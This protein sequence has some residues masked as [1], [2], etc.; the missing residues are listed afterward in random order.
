M[1]HPGIK[2][3][4]LAGKSVEDIPTY[5]LFLISPLYDLFFAE[6]SFNEANIE[7]LEIKGSFAKTTI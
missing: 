3:A 4:H 5:Y 6:N 7:L 2:I 1:I